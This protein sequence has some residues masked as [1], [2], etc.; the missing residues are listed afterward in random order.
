MGLFPWF[1]ATEAVMCVW[2]ERGRV[3]VYMCVC[4]CIYICVCVCTFVCVHVCV[5]VC[6]CMC[7]CI[8]TCVCACAHACVC[9]CVCAYACMCAPMCMCW[10][11]GP[12]R[13]IIPRITVLNFCHNWSHLPAL[14]NENLQ[15]QTYQQKRQKIPHHHPFP[16]PIP[17]QKSNNP[18]PKRDVIMSSV[19]VRT[20]L[21]NTHL[22][23]PGFQTFQ[24]SHVLTEHCCFHPC[25]SS[26]HKSANPHR[27]K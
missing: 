18:W 17:K 1:R 27:E 6:V 7:A 19:Q 11:R 23:R 13:A 5:C 9:V 26:R 22:N 2:G 10:G 14:C 4:V 24:W 16:P 25:Q 21:L 15:Q 20:S 8:H 12:P 3:H